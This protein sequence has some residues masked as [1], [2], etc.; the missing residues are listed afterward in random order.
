MAFYILTVKPDDGKQP[1]K[2]VT[3]PAGRREEKWH[4]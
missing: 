1:S 4:V 3:Q 2:T